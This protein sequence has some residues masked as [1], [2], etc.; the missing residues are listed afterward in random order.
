MTYD[1]NDI[2]Q[3]SVVNY[4]QWVGVVSWCTY[5]K[6]LNSPIPLSD[7]IANVHAHTV[8]C[9]SFCLRPRP[10]FVSIS[11]VIQISS[12][13]PWLTVF[14]TLAPTS[15]SNLLHLQFFLFRSV[16]FTCLSAILFYVSVDA[17]ECLVVCI[18][19]CQC[20]CIGWFVIISVCLVPCDVK[21]FVC[22]YMH[23]SV[24]NTRRQPICQK[25]TINLKK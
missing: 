20:F 3:L 1:D 4:R 18:H 9:P 23:K 2:I 21:A 25:N 13:S 14:F 5:V 12:S 22:A 8:C 16:C 17:Y 6:P 15:A 11:L 19:R 7:K 24:F 10:T